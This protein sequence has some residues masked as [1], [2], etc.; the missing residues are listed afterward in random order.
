MNDQE[1]QGTLPLDWAAATQPAV[2]PGTRSRFSESGAPGDGGR[3]IAIDLL[4]GLAVMGMIMVA[5]A[6]DWDHRFRVLT[7][8]DWRGFALAD[9]IF[10][11]FLFCVGAALPFSI[12]RRARR[13]KGA[14]IGHVLWR[15]AVLIVLGVVLNALPTFDWGHVRLMG[16]LQRIG[17]CYAVAG[18]VCVL[19]ARRRGDG[20][21]LDPRPLAVL[22]LALLAGYGALLLHW[23]APG[24]G[25]ACFDSAHSL[26]TVVDRAV[27]GIPHLWPYGTT[28]GVVTFDPEG[29]VST[30]GA[31][32][33][34]LIG[35]LAGLALLRPAASQRG[36]RG[37]LAWLAVAG[38]VC[39]AAGLAL[40]PFVPVVKKIWTPSFALLSGGF[41]L[42]ACAA[43]AW[44]VPAR[45]S[46]WTVP[47][48]SF[49][50]NA[51]LAFVGITLTDTV[52]Q[53]P[54]AA[55]HG[56]LHDAGAAALDRWIPD[57]RVASAAY[58]ALL[59]TVLGLGLWQLYRRRIFFRI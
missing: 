54:L 1:R 29:L 25:P 41:S 52:L 22:A 58:S 15:S 16:I 6:G 35:V 11:A 56:S 21:V 23:D 24:C 42:L 8:A 36:M 48:L 10:P 12:R 32:C 55:V 40:D 47:V 46:R 44:L 20:F 13:G 57:A 39:L 9:M 31:L 33:N 51:T 18:S 27:F 38:A 17:L 37:T 59:L 3:V 30:L 19:L 43:L 2:R 5:Y 49:G 4:R 45:A 53:L 14:L 28:A 26:P 34:V 7:H 50:T